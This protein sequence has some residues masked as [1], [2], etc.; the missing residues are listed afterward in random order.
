MDLKNIRINY[1]KSKIDFSN[2]EDNPIVFFLNWFE[3]ALRINKYEANACVLS[4]VSSQQKPSSRVVLL[5]DVS[6]KGFCVFYEL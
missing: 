1:K 5:K 3:D 2:L 6:Q 4:T